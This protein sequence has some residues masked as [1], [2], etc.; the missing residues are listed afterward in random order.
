[1]NNS[2]SSNLQTVDL[3]VYVLNERHNCTYI[4]TCYEEVLYQWSIP[5]ERVSLVVTDHASN[6][7]E[8]ELQHFPKKNTL[9]A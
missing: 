1:M 9:D 7:L 5:K 4:S 6:M 2:M 8:S 3:G